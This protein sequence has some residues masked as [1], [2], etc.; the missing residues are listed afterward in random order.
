MGLVFNGL[1]LGV[2]L[3]LTILGASRGIQREAMTLIGILLGA[4]LAELWGPI[5][6]P[7]NA[8]RF[9][10]D[11]ADT[12][13]WISIILLL[14]CTIFIGYGGALLLPSRKQLALGRSRW[15]GAGAGLFNGIL[16][17]SLILRYG[18][19]YNNDLMLSPWAASS[20]V[21]MVFIERF[22][23]MLLFGV[24]AIAVLVNLRL[25]QRLIFKIHGK[26]TKKE[27]KKK[28]EKK[29][30]DPPKPPEPKPPAPDTVNNPILRDLILAEIKKDKPPA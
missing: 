7:N 9:N 19:V 28:V 25:L 23:T 27:E 24:V 8:T 1:L 29:P 13:A 20:R 18:N 11:I 21:A 6:G 17:L 15:F 22:P 5:W 26:E 12:T 16:L 30:A 10:Q 3:G 2:P 4:L 14:I